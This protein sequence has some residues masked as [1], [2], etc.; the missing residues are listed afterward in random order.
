MYLD[1]D[2]HLHEQYV[3]QLIAGRVEPQRVK[4]QR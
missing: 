1:N 2:P 3:K 4:R